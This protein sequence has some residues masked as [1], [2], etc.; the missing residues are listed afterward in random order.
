MKKLSVGSGNEECTTLLRRPLSW[1][2]QCVYCSPS[3]GELI[4]GML[5][6]YTGK[7]IR[8]SSSGQHIL[9]IQHGNTGHT[10]YNVPHYITENTNGDIIVSDWIHYDRGAVVVTES[11]GRHRF[12]YTG[13]PSGSSLAPHGVC[14]DALS[15]ILVCDDHTDTVQMIDKDGHFLSLLL[16]RQHG[17]NKPWGLN[18]DDKTH[19]LWVGLRNT[20]I[21]SV[22]RYIQRKYSLTDDP[23]R[24]GRITEVSSYE[25]VQKSGREL[26][27]CEESECEE[28]SEGSREE[29]DPDEEDTAE[30]G[31]REDDIE[32][33]KG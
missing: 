17:I 7:V 14:T 19:L 3:T 1:R 26:E 29:S 31:T 21:V 11:R 20:N 6:N 8:Y 5:N 13:P 4:V 28:N 25:E 9:T 2:P 12:S 27:I 23:D 24:D 10:L 15:H 18:Y 30:S 32:E 33:E 22:Y 16:T